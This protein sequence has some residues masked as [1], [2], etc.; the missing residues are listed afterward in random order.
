MEK[1]QTRKFQIT[2][3]MVTVAVRVRSGYLDKTELLLHLMTNVGSFIQRALQDLK[4][5]IPNA[6]LFIEYLQIPK[7]HNKRCYQHGR[8]KTVTDTSQLG[9]YSSARLDDRNYGIYN[10][11]EF[12]VSKVPYPPASSTEI[13]DQTAFEPVTILSRS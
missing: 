12:K 4:K 13:I 7:M 8:R 9:S 1:S 10:I 11:Q 2:M 3:A 6:K 5:R